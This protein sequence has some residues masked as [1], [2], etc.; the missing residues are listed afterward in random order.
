MVHDLE[1]QSLSC[2]KSVLQKWYYKTRKALTMRV[3]FFEFRMLSATS[4]IS[5]QAFERTQLHP[6]STPRGLC[7]GSAL[8]R[9]AQLALMFFIIYSC[10]TVPF[11]LGFGA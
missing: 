8:K 11:R 4:F 7:I 10:V 3:R 2:Y 5:C 1:D 9:S 6:K